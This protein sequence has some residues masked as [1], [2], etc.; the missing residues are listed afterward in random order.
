MNKIYGTEFMVKSLTFISEPYCGVDTDSHGKIL[1]ELAE[2][3][4]AG[5]IKSYLQKSLRLDLNGL[6]KGHQTTE[7][8]RS[9][10]MVG[11]SVNVE[12]KGGNPPFT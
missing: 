11:L 5:K 6:R 2:L 10:G 12:I 8:G 3:I 9:M 1:K 7:D 4:D